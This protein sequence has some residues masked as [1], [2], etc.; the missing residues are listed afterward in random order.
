MQKNNILNKVFFGIGFAALVVL[1]GC[2]EPSVQTKK[3][4]QIDFVDELNEL[5]NNQL[6]KNEKIWFVGIGSFGFDGSI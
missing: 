1:N 5:S 4:T 3:M 6:T 2:G